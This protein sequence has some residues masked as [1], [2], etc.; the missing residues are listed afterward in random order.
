MIKADL[1]IGLMPASVPI[2]EDIVRIRLKGG[3]K[4]RTIKAYT[5]CPATASSKAPKSTRRR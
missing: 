5:V 1:G 3:L 4:H 2:R